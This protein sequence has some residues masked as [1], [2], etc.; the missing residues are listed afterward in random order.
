LIAVSAD[1]IFDCN[2]DLNGSAYVDACH[3][4]VGGN[5]GN[6]SCEDCMGVPNGEAVINGCGDCVGGSSPVNPSNE[7][8]F[9]SLINWDLN[10]RLSGYSNSGYAILSVLGT[11]PYMSYNGTVCLDTDV[12]NILELKIKNNTNGAGAALYYQN[13]VTNS[14]NFKTIQV[15][16]NDDEINTYT[17]DLSG[18]DSWVGNIH[19]I[20]FDPPGSSGSFLLDYLAVKGVPSAIGDR[21]MANEY[22]STGISLFPNPATKRFTVK[23]DIESKIVV[24]DSGGME[25]YRNNNLQGQHIVEAENWNA[26][27]YMV[28]VVNSSESRIVKIVVS[29]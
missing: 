3:N 7:W 23:T 25:V 22:T 14:W 10:P 1:G 15:S 2:G 17:V 18:E 29:N 27:L 11:D 24:F 28:Q 4:C 20:R 13:D 19:T 26:G 5:T 9:N 21:T 6:E 16:N 8:P 12:L